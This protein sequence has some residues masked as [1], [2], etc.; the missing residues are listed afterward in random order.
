[1]RGLMFLAEL[2]S[3]ELLLD[4][5]FSAADSNAGSRVKQYTKDSLMNCFTT[6]LEISS[7]ATGTLHV[8]HPSVR[9]IA[10][11]KQDL[12]KI[13]PRMHCTASFT[14]SKHIGQLKREIAS[15]SRKSAE[16]KQIGGASITVCFAITK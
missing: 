8:G 16:L 10:S 6:R 13:C 3:L 7:L 1:M 11:S 4:P 12:Q 5:R 2:E 15:G 14:T 9:L